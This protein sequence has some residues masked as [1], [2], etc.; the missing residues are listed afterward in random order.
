MNA[1]KLLMSVQGFKEFSSDALE[2][3]SV[4]NSSGLAPPRQMTSDHNNSELGIHDHSNEPSSSKLVPKVVPPA[5][6]T[7]TSRQEL[8]LLFQ[9]HITMLRVLRIILV[10]VPEHPSDTY[11]LTM[12]MEILLEPASNKLLVGT[13]N[14]ASKTM[15]DAQAHYTTTEKELLAMVY[16]FEKFWLYLVL[17]KT[18]V[19]TDHSALKY[20]LAKQ[21]AKLRLLCLD[22]FVEIPSGESKVHIEVLSVL[23]GN[24]LPI[25][26]GSLSLSSLSPALFELLSYAIS[27]SAFFEFSSS[28]VSAFLEL[29]STNSVR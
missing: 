16:D 20:L 13:Y 1:N 4:H 14:Y 25:L 24:R 21:D 8:E 23:W 5:D 11:V 28:S 2:M 10:I 9:H 19:Y 18:I 26:D 15:T 27:A 22:P 17:S 12:K 3:T 29:S 7:T 6:K